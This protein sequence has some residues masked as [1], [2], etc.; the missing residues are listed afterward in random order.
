MLEL[1]LVLLACVAFML[2][3]TGSIIGPV[4]ALTA[5]FFV[6]GEPLGLQGWS[7]VG[8]IAFGPMIL[9]GWR[10]SR[11]NKSAILTVR[12]NTPVS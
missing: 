11:H 8:A 2:W 3:I 4:I 12:S 10:E 7:I 1:G 5:A 6:I 9:R